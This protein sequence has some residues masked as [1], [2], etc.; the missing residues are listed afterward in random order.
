[1]YLCY[2]DIADKSDFVCLFFGP[3]EHHSS[4]WT[5]NDN[6]YHYFSD[7]FF[8]IEQEYQNVPWFLDRYHNFI[9]INVYVFNERM[10]YIG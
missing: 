3:H 5:I 2:F 4:I 10:Y 9:I 7:F 8:T 1:M 6:N